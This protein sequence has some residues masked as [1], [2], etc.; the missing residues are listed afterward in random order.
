MIK[1]PTQFLFLMCIFLLEI[2]VAKSNQELSTPIYYQ[3][4]HEQSYLY[5]APDINSPLVR[6]LYIGEMIKAI[7]LV[8]TEKGLDWYKIEIGLES[9][10]YIKASKLNQ[11]TDLPENYWQPSKVIRSERPLSLG[12]RVSG[13]TYG[14]G[15]NLRYMPFSGLGLSITAG[16]VLDDSEMKGTGISFGIVSISSTEKFSPTFELG[17]SRFSYHDDKSALRITAFYASLGLEYMYDSGLFINTGLT[18]V[19]SLDI[20]VIYEFEDARDGNL[21][22]GDYG[23]FNYL[24]EENSLQDVNLSFT[25]GYAF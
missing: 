1:L 4:Q 22:I 20:E 8:K 15:A 12:V 9:F 16:P 19:R 2:E 3:I 6:R 23:R 13:E 14:A 17:I 18:Y 5:K 10:A 7:E 21:T 24:K 11:I 25:V